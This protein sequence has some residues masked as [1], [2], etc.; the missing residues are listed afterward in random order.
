MSRIIELGEASG[1]FGNDYLLLSSPTAGERKIL[2][3][4]FKGSGGSSAIYL[5]QTQ[6]DALTTEEKENGSIYFVEIP[7]SDW[8][9]LHTSTQ[10]SYEYSA[11]PAY[12]KYLVAAESLNNIMY[13][14]IHYT[15][16]N[17][18]SR[19]MTT[20]ELS[21]LAS[22]IS[23]TS[24]WAGTQNISGS[25]TTTPSNSWSQGSN[26]D[27]LYLNATS[28]DNVGTKANFSG[29]KSHLFYKTDGVR[30][31]YYMNKL[32]SEIIL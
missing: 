24:N 10:G 20:E 26:N 23:M 7:A 5:T 17:K 32:W 21:H 9:F 13:A 15:I 16:S 1:I 25:G 18:A 29:C 14:S 2:A 22:L 28:L 11:V 8:E 3:Q 31:I 12:A 30:R 6:Y 4:N 27:V 19:Y